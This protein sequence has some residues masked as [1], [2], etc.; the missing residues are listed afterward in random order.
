M[1][2]I[3]RILASSAALSMF[4]TARC[5]SAE[6]SMKRKFE[7]LYPSL[8]KLFGFE[9]I[10]FPESTPEVAERVSKS[11]RVELLFEEH[12]FGLEQVNRY[13]LF[14]S[15]ENV[16][17]SLRPRFYLGVYSGLNGAI[18]KVF[19]PIEGLSN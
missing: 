15:M 13:V 10:P 16:Q 9:G 8:D 19:G 3:R 12:K 2:R 1:D 4:G 7:S 18:F 6:N 11:S 17:F 5:A 14:T